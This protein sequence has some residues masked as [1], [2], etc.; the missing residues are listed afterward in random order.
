MH[1][2]A[3]AGQVIVPLQ[4]AIPWLVRPCSVRGR[5]GIRIA[6]RVLIAFD[7]R[8]AIDRKR[9]IRT[10]LIKLRDLGRPRNAAFDTDL[11][12]WFNSFQLVEATNG[13]V[14]VVGSIP[15]LQR[16]TNIQTGPLD[17]GW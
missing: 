7:L 13:D 6:I 1:Q 9:L 15:T 4:W 14:E 16:R 8:C 2:G 3:F 17:G 5:P 12:L 10:L 11:D